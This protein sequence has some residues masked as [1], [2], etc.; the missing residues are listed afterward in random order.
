MDIAS[1]SMAMSMSKA[2]SEAGVA[3]TK[4]AM[5]TGKENASQMTDM[6]KSPVTDPNLG[7][8]VDVRI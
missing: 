6:M 5:D 2:Q 3:I 4:I 1:L 8:Y 7:N